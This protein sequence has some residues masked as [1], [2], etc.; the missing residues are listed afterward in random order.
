MPSW[1][2]TGPV[3]GQNT[4]DTVWFSLVGFYGISILVGYLILNPVYTYISNIYDL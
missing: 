2:E 4:N 1:F 3:V